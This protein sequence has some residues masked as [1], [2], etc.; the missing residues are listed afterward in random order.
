MRIDARANTLG[1]LLAHAAAEDG[2]RTFLVEDGKAITFA[3]M[4][5]RADAV[6]SALL[7][8]GYKPGDRVAIA[9]TNRSAWVE[10]LLGVTQVGMV[11]V[12]LNI[13]Y[14]REELS[15]M[16][17]R[18]GASAAITPSTHQDFDLAALYR[19][20][21]HELPAL[22][23]VFYLDGPPGE[24]SF[25]EL[26]DG[27]DVD[28]AEVM[29]SVKAEDPALI[30]FTSGT[31]GRPKGAT[32]THRS[33]IASGR[34]Q[35]EHFGMLP[36]DRMCGHMPFNHVG[37][38]TCTL[39]ASLVA[40]SSVAL[41]ENFTPRGAID[42]IANGGL[43]VFSGVPT[44][45]VLMLADPGFADLDTSAIRLLVAGGANV[46]PS[47]LAKIR[48]AFPA[49]T[50]S[51]LYGLSETSG[52]CII[53]P[54]DDNDSEVASTLG[55]A[56]GDFELRAVAPNGA[57]T[58]TG[59]DGELQVKGDCVVAGY[60]E[61]PVATKAAIDDDGWLST[62]DIVSIAADGH[63]TLRGRRKEMF[64]QGGYNVYPVEVE[65]VLTSHPGVAMAAGIGVPDPVLGEVGRYYI[66]P[67]GE[68]APSPEELDA[69]CREHLADYKVPREYVFA[70][71]LP[72]T[73]V[74][75][76]QKSILADVVPGQVRRARKP[77]T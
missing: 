75:K 15:Y 12:T 22:K 11:L 38:V 32:I 62:G 5:R 35:A 74:G 60:W 7:Q 25:A 44:M 47:L 28:F 20:V 50:I 61:D 45:F 33:I 27:G 8:R 30:L 69:Y 66:V 58:A 6:S 67:R 10:A 41:L 42:L 77:G 37:G 73:P 40:R 55:K 68:S 49:A 3:E 59:T 17:A 9:G 21:R 29:A 4:K 2:S 16:L 34:A 53:S 52:A 71:A 31:T 18:S 46:E 51:N 56:I 24:P 13:R 36:E 70:Q 1:A 14:R 26:E 57:P 54:L 76:I 63:V 23:E 65:N 39:V 43:T 72:L 64:I 48:S 19:D